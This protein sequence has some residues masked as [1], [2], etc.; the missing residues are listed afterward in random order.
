MQGQLKQGLTIL[1][2]TPSVVLESQ[3]GGGLRATS[4]DHD[5]LG[6]DL[7]PSKKSVNRDQPV[8]AWTNRINPEQHGATRDSSVSH[9][10]VV[11]SRF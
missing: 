2:R 6:S 4:G 7:I 11:L 8:A 1:N 3:G 9:V 5:S 10:N